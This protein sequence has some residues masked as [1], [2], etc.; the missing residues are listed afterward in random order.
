MTESRRLLEGWKKRN[1]GV[2]SHRSLRR[3]KLQGKLKW[4]NIQGRRSDGIWDG[5]GLRHWKC[6]GV[7]LPGKLKKGEGCGGG[8]RDCLGEV[9]ECT[10]WNSA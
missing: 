10:A 7:G 5:E 4:P 1:G 2:N 8:D 3:R 9:Y 6:G